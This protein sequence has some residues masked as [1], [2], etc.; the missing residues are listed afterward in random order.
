[1]YDFVW[2]DEGNAREVINR[3]QKLRKKAGLVPADK[4]T[5]YLE[6]DQALQQVID[7]FGDFIQKTVKATILQLKDAPKDSVFLIEEKFQDVSYLLLFFFNPLLK[8][9]LKVTFV[10]LNHFFYN[11]R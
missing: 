11:S 4:V 6:A 10:K 7:G 8:L 3:I 9:K 5:V 1:M 2:Q